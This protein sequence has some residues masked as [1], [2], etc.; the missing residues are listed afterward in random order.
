[1]GR[2]NGTPR[3]RLLAGKWNVGSPE[4]VER[5]GQAGVALPSRENSARFTVDEFAMAKGR[6][7]GWVNCKVDPALSDLLVEISAFWDAA[8]QAQQIGQGK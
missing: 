1:L 4:F 6:V 8:L 5:N 3:E 2:L 7:P